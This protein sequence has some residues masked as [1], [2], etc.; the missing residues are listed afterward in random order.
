MI[1]DNLIKLFNIIS[2][3][4]GMYM[5]LEMLFDHE[6]FDVLKFMRMHGAKSISLDISGYFERYP[7]KFK[8]FWGI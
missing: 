3:S 7:K 1:N 6:P 5:Q 4:F 8:I 2:A